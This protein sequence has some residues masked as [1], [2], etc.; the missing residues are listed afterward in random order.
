MLSFTFCKK[1]FCISAKKSKYLR[2]V[3]FL[4]LTI[5]KLIEIDFILLYLS[6]SVAGQRG[7]YNAWTSHQAIVV[8]CLGD[9]NV[10]L[11]G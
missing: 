8:T 3:S 4:C 11:S 5:F 6:S 2:R 7:V 10:L 9:A 1:I